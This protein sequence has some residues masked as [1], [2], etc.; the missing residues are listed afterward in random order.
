MLPDDLN[1]IY[2]QL[3]PL[4]TAHGFEPG[5]KP[6][7]YQEVIDYGEFSKCSMIQSNLNT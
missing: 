5:T 6:F 4:N 2:S 7:I 1:Y 3:N